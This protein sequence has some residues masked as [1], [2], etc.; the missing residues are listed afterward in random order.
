MVL[1]SPSD[2]KRVPAVLLPSGRVLGLNLLYSS[3]SFNHSLFSVLQSNESTHSPSVLSLPCA[4]CSIR[5]RGFL[6]YSISTS[7]ALLCV[8][9]CCTEAATSA[10][11]S[12]GGTAL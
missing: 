2:P 10:L 9:S 3:C 6:H 1:A 8:L 12:S 11:R 5:G 7:L 4:V